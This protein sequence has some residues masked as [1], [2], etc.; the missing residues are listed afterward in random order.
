M[1]EPAAPRG[2]A[3]M[4]HPQHCPPWC[5]DCS[6]YDTDPYAPLAHLHRGTAT[7]VPVYDEAWELVD[8]RVRTAFWDKEP[9]WIGTDPTDLE[10][11]YVEVIIVSH[12]GIE[13]SL[14]PGQAR[15]L[16]A[17]LLQAAKGADAARAALDPAAA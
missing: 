5:A 4:P 6:H 11:P 9:A 3:G 14:T 17:A 2:T 15:G 10:Q 12:G 13:V 1:D 8:A 7:T 16:A